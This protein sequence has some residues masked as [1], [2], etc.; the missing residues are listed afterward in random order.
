MPVV[1]CSVNTLVPSSLV[2]TVVVIFVV[3]PA[4]NS[5]LNRI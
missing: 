5:R 3:M 2:V 1:I 4:N